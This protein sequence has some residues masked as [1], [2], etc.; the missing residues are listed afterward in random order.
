MSFNNEFTMVGA[1]FVN[2]GGES[3]DINDLFSAEGNSLPGMTDDGDFQTTLLV[4][5]GTGYDTYGW[6]DADDGTN[7]EWEEA[8]SKWLLYDGSDIAQVDMSAGK[9]FW[10]RTNGSQAAV[11]TSGEVPDA[12]AE[13]VAIAN[14]FTMIA[15]PRPSGLNIQKIVPSETIP[16]MTD[17]GDFQTTLLVWTGTG[18]DTYG[19]ADADD[20]TNNEWE[21]ANSKWLLYDGSDIAD[22]T[23]PMGTAMWFRTKTTTSGS[24]SFAE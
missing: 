23:I 3:K 22:V 8:N 14:E 10:L 20:G 15:N 2:V 12:A 7:N 18:Y 19:W 6:A 17:D 21:E 4:W 11:T 1:Q 5:T 24:V 9:A 16:G 13:P